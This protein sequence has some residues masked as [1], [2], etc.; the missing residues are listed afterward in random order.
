MEVW[1]EVCGSGEVFVVVVGKN[2]EAFALLIRKARESHVP[3]LT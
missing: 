1:S 3:L 2:V